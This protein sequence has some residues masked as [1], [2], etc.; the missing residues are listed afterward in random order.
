MIHGMPMIGHCYHRAK[1]CSDLV[2]TYV[3]TCN[4]EIYDYIE[5]IGGKA[6]MTK[7]THE[8]A[9]DRTAEAMLKIEKELGFELDV[10]VMVQGDEPMTTPSMISQSLQPFHKDSSVNVVNL[11][12]EMASNEEFEDENEVKVVVDKNS[13]A[14][15]F[16][17]EPIPSKKKG[18]VSGPML[19]QVCV[20]PFRREYL[21]K[22]N[23]TSET[24]LEIIESIDML[25]II[26]NSEKVKMVYSDTQ[27]FSVD[28][29]KDL[30]KV[31]LKMEN[32][33]L[34]KIY[35]SN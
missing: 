15:Y 23:E 25:R 35:L 8:R 14:I 6:V 24:E 29:E 5:S 34:M 16:S 31:S 13:N 10:V 19:K 33:E 21:L 9:T 30:T 3:A 17:R 2:D 22:F 1:M 12:I 4:Q 11:M 27:S 18:V 32:D 28:T 26:E 20:I 7:S